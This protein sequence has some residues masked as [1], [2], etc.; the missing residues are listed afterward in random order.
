MKNIVKITLLIAILLLSISFVSAN[1]NITDEPTDLLKTSLSE[2]NLTNVNE[3]EPLS[4]EKED[5]LTVAVINDTIYTVTDECTYT[6]TNETVYTATSD[7]LLTYTN[8][9]EQSTAADRTFKMGKYKITLSKSQYSALLYAKQKD[10]KNYGEYYY[11]DYGDKYG[12]YEVMTYY[13]ES[14][15][16]LCVINFG[17]L[18]FDDCEK[19]LRYYIEKYTGKTVKQ[20]LG[21]GFKGYKYVTK[22]T[23]ST[24]AKAKNY[25]K[26]LRHQYQY[27]IK[28]VKIKNKVK[29]RVYKEV[30]KYKKVVTKKAKVYIQIHYGAGQYGVPEKY[31][32]HLYSQYENPGYE[33]VSGGLFCSKTS[34]SLNG[35]KTAKIKYY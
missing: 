18:S 2:T 6:A 29:Y 28:K 4:S 26:T 33:V 30:P 22:K 34:G 17:S 25:K 16:D 20:K 15:D 27:V 11:L 9:V 13:K 21:Y 3:E 23:F 7:P 5:I 32:M 35:L 24:K 10:F 8:V 31:A 14:I 12:P 19:G 1:E